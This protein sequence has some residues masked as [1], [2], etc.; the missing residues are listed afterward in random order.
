MPPTQP[1]TLPDGLRLYAIGDVHGCRGHLRKLIDKIAA[2]AAEDPS[3]TI[4]LVFVG[5]YVDR[6]PDSAGVIDDILALRRDGL[7][8]GRPVELVTLMGNHE[9]Y[10]IRFL[11]GALDIAPQWMMNGGA[12]TIES[13]D[14][15]PPRLHDDPAELARAARGLVAALPPAHRAF[16]EGLDYGHRAGGYFFVH[17]GVRPGVPLDEQDPSEMMWIRAPFLESASDFGALVVHGHTPV[18][19]VVERANRIDIDTGAVYGG[20][21]TAACFWGTERRFLQVGF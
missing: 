5:D 18:P 6:G 14:V 16:L 15:E 4:R 17:A 1:A 21:L 19:E 13:Y 9:D 8:D 2:D 3:A 11:D 7:P 20:H 10:F 12:E